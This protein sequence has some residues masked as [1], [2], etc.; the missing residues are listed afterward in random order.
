VPADQTVSLAVEG[1]SFESAVNL[2]LSPLGLTWLDDD[3]SFVVLT[4][5]GC[6]YA[7]QM[8][9]YHVPHLLGEP[10]LEP[11]YETL[12][13]ILNSHVGVSAEEWD[14]IN[15]IPGGVVIVESPQAHE[16]IERLLA[17]LAW[18][19][20][21]ERFRRPDDGTPA[22]VAAIREALARPVT[23]QAND[24]PLAEIAKELARQAG[25]KNVVL[26][27]WA[28]D[29]TGNEPSVRVSFQTAGQPLA[30][31]LD[32][33]LDQRSLT[34]LIENEVLT[35]TSA[36]DA[37]N[38]LQTHCY[39]VAAPYVRYGHA[40]DGSEGFALDEFCRLIPLVIDP[41]SWNERGG[42]GSISAYP[43]GLV[44]SQ[45]QRHHQAVGRLLAEEGLGE[46]LGA[47][48]DAADGP[49]AIAAMRAALADDRPFVRVVAVMLLA[50]RPELA[51]GCL[52]ELRAALQHSE[53]ALRQAILKLFGTLG[54]AA[55]PAVP[56]LTD[57]LGGYHSALAV[58]VLGEIGP[59][60][61]PAV[62]ALTKLLEN[63][64]FAQRLN[65]L[66]YH[67][68][69]TLGKIGPA[70]VP[71]LL[72]VLCTGDPGPSP[73]AAADELVR[74]EADLSEALPRL[75]A[76]LADPYDLR[77]GPVCEVLG[78]MGPAAR[79]AVRPIVGVLVTPNVA[80]RVAACDALGTIGSEAELA[81]PALIR[82]LDAPE[83][84]VRQ[85]ASV[86]LGRFGPAAIPAQARLRVLT[87]DPRDPVRQA[88]E[89]ALEAIR[90]SGEQDLEGNPP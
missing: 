64:D 8:R 49:D 12:I 44:V 20:D 83:G 70:A 11:D 72:D 81:V 54:P 85:A 4:E 79:P 36:E 33:L 61:A 89:G 39:R 86:A 88:A 45:T 40:S 80:N 62:A 57:L 65:G 6:S 1:V 37:G 43:G 5:E 63:C 30:D 3:E 38:T 48:V 27:K 18:L 50:D 29:D 67:I 76:V 10:G 31:A 26:D 75:T 16:R 84:D 13:D 42:M 34:W 2:T 71:V 66:E 87:Q 15:A 68:I 90:Q 22:T 82:A 69:A 17:G 24:A 32:A 47:L 19:V 52:A 59:A 14:W 46:A 74:I 77:C 51:A 41:E 78:S 58:H 73:Q 28:W 60:A 25:V 55:A 35:F 7:H 53:P 23:F 9:I 56:E 21:S